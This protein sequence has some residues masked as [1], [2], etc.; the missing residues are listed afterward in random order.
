MQSL[1]K[2][3]PAVAASAVVL[4]ATATI[5]T[6][7]FSPVTAQARQQSSMTFAALERR[8]TALGIR[9]TELKIKDRL[10]E[11]EGWDRDG[12]KVEVKIDTQSG[13][14]LHREFDDD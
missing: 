7:S 6:S 12:R 14:V 11:I 10:A 4:V 9:P 5:G 1:F 2:V 8:A 3:V 13:E